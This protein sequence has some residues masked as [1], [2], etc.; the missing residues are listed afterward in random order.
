MKTELV[1]ARLPKENT[2]ILDEVAKEEKTDKTTALKKI[3][4]LGAKQYRLEKAIREYQQGKIGLGGAAEKSGI[5]LWEMMEELKAKNIASPLK[6]EDY[7]EGLKNLRKA[8]K[9]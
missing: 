5:S 1:S 3:F 7:E 8:M 9:R 4:E 6:K 2:A